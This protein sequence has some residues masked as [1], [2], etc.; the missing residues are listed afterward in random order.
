MFKTT[1]L[2]LSAA[3]LFFATGCVHDGGPTLFPNPDPNLRMTSEQFAAASA[4]RVYPAS[5]RRAKEPKARAQ[6][7]YSLNRVEIV[8]FTN[9]DWRDVEVWVNGTHS[10][11][12]PYM[13]DRKLK[14]VHFPML[15]DQNGNSF[16]MDN[17]RTRV[18]RVEVLR[19]GVLYE[20]VC[21]NADW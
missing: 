9:E 19:N 7:A 4:K 18:N 12:V 8:N 13:Q 6:A 21:H 2:T 1:T 14:E 17:S 5:A 15:F 11:F 16:P 20:L 3:T 10:C